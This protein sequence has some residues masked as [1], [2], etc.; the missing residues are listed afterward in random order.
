MREDPHSIQGPGRKWTVDSTGGLTEERQRCVQRQP[1]TDRNQNLQSTDN[2]EKKRQ[3][4][5]DIAEACFLNCPTSTST[6]YPS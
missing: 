2:T 6:P 4:Y 5:V 3:R 1:K